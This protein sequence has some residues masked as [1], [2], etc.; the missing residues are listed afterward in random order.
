MKREKALGVIVLVLSIAAISLASVPDQPYMQAARTDLQKARAALQR[1]EH[2]KGGHRATAIGLINSAIV[3]VNLGINFDRRFIRRRNHA[4][5]VLKGFSPGV[6]LAAVDQPNMRTA[7]NHLQSAKRN[8]QSATADKG[9][10]RKNAIDLVNRAIDEVNR[11][12]AAGN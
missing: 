7:L 11:G 10:H 2:N 3:E 6:D 1:A 12:I 5:S 8:L 4:G 9:G